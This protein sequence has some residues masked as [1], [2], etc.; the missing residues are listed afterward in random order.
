MKIPHDR[1][2]VFL[3]MQETGKVPGY[4]CAHRKI[5]SLTQQN[6][7]ASKITL[8]EEARDEVCK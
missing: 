6:K 3:L 5:F 4:S 2:L 7:V 1:V 8:E